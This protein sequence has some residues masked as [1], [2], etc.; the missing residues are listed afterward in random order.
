MTVSIAKGAAGLFFRENF[1]ATLPTLRTERLL[2]R[3]VTMRDVQDI[4]EVSSDPRVSRYVMWHAHASLLDSRE[5]I[6]GIQRNY[7]MDRPSPWAIELVEE[8]KLIGTIGYVSMNREHRSA[9]VGYSLG[10]AHWNQG[11][12]TE[13]LREVM[14]FS[15]EQLEL[16]RIEAQHDIRNPASGRV[17]EKAGMTKEGTLRDRLMNKGEFI[18]VDLYAALSGG[19]ANSIGRY[20]DFFL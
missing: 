11:Y 7:R 13:A 4:Y 10:H 16:H 5:Y 15:F 17:M 19:E 1:F 12:A 3:R 6:R 8:G 9:E 2:L 20:R 14:T 18:T